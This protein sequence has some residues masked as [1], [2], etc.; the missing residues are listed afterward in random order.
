MFSVFNNFNNNIN[1][2]YIYIYISAEHHELTEINYVYNDV[3]HI[4]TF[5]DSH[6]ASHSKHHSHRYNRVTVTMCA[7][8]N[9]ELSKRGKVK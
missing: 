5:T 3:T 8:R 6:S 2:I 4:K 7:A 9:S 1:A